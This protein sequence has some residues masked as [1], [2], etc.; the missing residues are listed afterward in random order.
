M[1]TKRNSSIELLR[2]VAM[3][4]IIAQHYV[5]HADYDRS[6]FDTVSA[7]VVYLK[8]LSM[9]GYSACTFFGL[10]SGYHLIRKDTGKGFYQKLVPLILE[11]TFYSV[12]IMAIASSCGLV[13]LSLK[14][15][16]KQIL[17]VFYG[18]WYVVFYIVLYLFAPF[19]NPFLKAME[20][21]E[22]RKLLFLCGV[23]FIA[24]QTF[25][26]EVYDLGNIDFMF[27]SYIFG[28]YVQLY[29]EDFSYKNICNLL[30][31]LG[32]A[33]LIVASLIVLDLLG[34]KTGNVKFIHNDTFLIRWD[35]L[36]QFAFSLFIFLYAV[37]KQFHNSFIDLFGSAVLGVYLIHDGLFRN[38]IWNKIW[39]NVF[40]VESPYLHSI[41][42][43]LAVFAVCALIDILRQL[44][45]ERPLLKALKRTK[46]YERL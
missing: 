43:I 45:L 44:L 8:A 42:K 11:T 9:F 23:L 21:K 35:S 14:D 31:G 33:L 10:I 37:K 18:N 29:P 20:K 22:Y 1:K 26:G 34:L 32:M 39:P 3:L 17:A 4:M 24:L 6:I 13:S 2:I 25:L 19:I 46:L 16:A 12:T 27:L 5:Y 30:A 41:L 28:A 38:L 36:P 15:M 7:N 40:Y